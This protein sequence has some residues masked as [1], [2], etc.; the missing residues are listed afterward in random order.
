MYLENS[1]WKAIWNF[2]RNKDSSPAIEDTPDNAGIVHI[3]ATLWEVE[4]DNIVKLDH[5]S[6]WKISIHEFA[7][8]KQHELGK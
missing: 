8:K 5:N 4:H 6:N 3:L 1:L 7:L 2:W